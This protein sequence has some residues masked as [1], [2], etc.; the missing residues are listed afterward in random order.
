VSALKTATSEAS[1]REKQGT[2]MDAKLTVLNGPT[3]GQTFQ[4]PRGKLLIGRAEDC[5]LR[6]DSEVVSGYHCVLLL[7]D[8]TLR[9]RDL[10]SK[11]G[12]RVNGRRI[13]AG[14]TILVHD[15][16]VSV[17]DLQL[18]VDLT[19]ARARIEPPDSGTQLPVSPAS[20]EK[21]GLIDGDTLQDRISGATVSSV[22]PKSVSPSV[23]STS[24]PPLTE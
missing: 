5:D 1:R 10:A 17:G 9:V 3:A 14:S 20:L 16:V 4:V 24:G 15:D 11:N 23:S 22:P 19:Q 21:T 2:R 7:D 18:R 6:P 8:Y 13:G 12:T